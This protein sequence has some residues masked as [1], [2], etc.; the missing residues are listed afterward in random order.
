V[1]RENRLIQAE[2]LRNVHRTGLHTAAGETNK[3][4]E[5]AA[6]G[7]IFVD[8]WRL[9]CR[10]R[11]N[12]RS[13]R[14]SGSEGLPQENPKNCGNACAAD[15]RNVRSDKFDGMEVVLQI[16]QFLVFVLGFRFSVLGTENQT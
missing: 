12:G 1:D 5:R 3:T 4:C 9:P 6:V 8:L 14:M 11:G 16:C 10:R 15:D 2:N 7:N 13:A